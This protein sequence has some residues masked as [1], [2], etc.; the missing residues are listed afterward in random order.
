[1]RRAIGAAGA[2]LLLPAALQSGSHSNR[3]AFAT[4]K[5]LLRKAAK[6]TVE[7]T[8][9][10]IGTLLACFTSSAPTTSSTQDKLQRKRLKLSN[11]PSAWL[12]RFCPGP[13]RD[14]ADHLSSRSLEDVKANLG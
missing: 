11:Q 3:K 10:R 8:W 2:R 6:R 7:A 9:K 5:T 14:V 1:M 12:I 4:L 13:L